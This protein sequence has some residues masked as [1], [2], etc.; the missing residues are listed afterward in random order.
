MGQQV[1]GQR[2]GVTSSPREAFERVVTLLEDAEG[3]AQREWVRTRGTSTVM[4]HA[5][6]EA[7]W[8]DIVQFRETAARCA[9]GSTVVWLT[10]VLEVVASRRDAAGGPG[11]VGGEGR[12]LHR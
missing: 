10:S 7:G 12:L 11:L 8:R 4:A 1:E 9:D 2:R 5:A 3:E 6:S